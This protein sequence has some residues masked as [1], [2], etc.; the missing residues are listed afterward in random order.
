MLNVFIVYVKVMRLFLMIL[1]DETNNAIM[2][3]LL[4][5]GGR[6]DKVAIFPCSNTQLLKML[7]CYIFLL[8]CRV[9]LHTN[10]I[11]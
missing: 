8:L 6:I 3:T 4:P 1:F 7:Y 2:L 5:G 9:T 10:T 11:Q